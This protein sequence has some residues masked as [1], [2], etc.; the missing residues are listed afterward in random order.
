[1][2]DKLTDEL[3]SL[4]ERV[5][6]IYLYGEQHMPSYK[7]RIVKYTAETKKEIIAYINTLIPA[8]IAIFNLRIDSAE[9]AAASQIGFNDCIKKVRENFQEGG[10]TE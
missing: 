1:M 6:F 9:K 3:Y 5:E 8:E 2:N 7:D 10:L 4:I